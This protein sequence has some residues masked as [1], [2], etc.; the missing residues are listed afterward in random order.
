MRG[1]AA[2]LGASLGGY[3]QAEQHEPDEDGGQGGGQSAQGEGAELLR[4]D[5]APVREVRHSEQREPHAESGHDGAGHIEVA[6]IAGEGGA[7]NEP[8]AAQHEHEIDGHD[9]EGEAEARRV[10]NDAQGQRGERRERGRPGNGAERDGPL[11]PLVERRDQPEHRGRDKAGAK[12]H[13][14]APAPG[15]GE[16]VGGERRH[17]LARNGQGQPHGQ[18]AVQADGH[19]DEPSGYH[20]RAGDER[21]QRGGHLD[22]VEGGAQRAHEAC[23][24]KVH[25]RAVA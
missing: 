7:G 2:T 9:G 23:R 25:G 13:D 18:C 4:I 11:P 1:V 12:S 19:A 24:R 5:D 17:H 10:H 21:E 3:E 6:V 20:E 22:I 8:R 16:D 15:E 14:D